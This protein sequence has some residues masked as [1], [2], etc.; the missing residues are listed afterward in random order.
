MKRE[1]RNGIRLSEGW[2]GGRKRRITVP[3]VF[4]KNP[5]RKGERGEGVDLAFPFRAVGGRKG[6]AFR[7]AMRACG[8]KKDSARE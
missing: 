4:I 3:A 2:R 6:G 8:V 1:K 5:T 7:A